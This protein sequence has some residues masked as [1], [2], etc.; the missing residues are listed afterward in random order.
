M[1]FDWAT[2]LTGGLGALAGFSG[3]NASNKRAPKGINYQPYNGYRPPHID[4]TD[5]SGKQVNNLRNVQQSITDTLM[6]RSQ[7][8]DVGYDP[9]LISK[10]KENFNI[11]QKQQDERN[12]AALDNELSGTGM[13]R[14]LAARDL[15]VNRLTQDENREQNKAF[16]D[17]DIASMER[18]NQEKQAATSG[19]QGLNSFDFGQENNAANFDLG[20]YGAEN[21]A[22][23]GAFNTQQTA[24]GDYQDPAG[25]AI[26]GAGA[27]AGA[28]S[29]LQTNQALIAALNR[30]AQPAA[31]PTF[32]S[33]G[34]NP[35]GSPSYMFNYGQYSV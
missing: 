22:K 16:N 7:G 1:A 10:S 20:V 27:G 14:N 17:I 30:N 19:L 21:G 33:G 24:F 35:A 9:A 8:Q 3:A 13:S 31:S 5:P 15:T 23:Q 28:V 6:R 32:G 2:A 12:R 34:Q 25:S 18:A 4:Y 26:A 29:G 11:N